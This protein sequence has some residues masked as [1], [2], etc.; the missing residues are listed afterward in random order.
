MIGIALAGL[1]DVAFV[2][3]SAY[4]HDDAIR[5]AHPGWPAARQ[6]IVGILF[7]GTAGPLL[8]FWILTR[9]GHW[10]D[11]KDLVE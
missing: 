4:V 1:V 9:L 2:C 10:L 8:T 6:S 7:Y 5:A 3:T 11:E